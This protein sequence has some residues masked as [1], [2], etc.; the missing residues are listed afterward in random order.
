MLGHMSTQPSKEAV[1]RAGRRLASVLTTL[2]EDDREKVAQLEAENTDEVDDA[3]ALVDWWRSQ[4]AKP[5]TSV[6]ANLRHYVKPHGHRGHILVTQRLKR[7]PTVID[8]LL[9]EPHMKLTQ[10]AD[11]GVAA[12]CCPTKPLSIR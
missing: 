1:N 12:R 9:R 2:R 6:G 8:K 3:F 4:H 5:L 10:M 11:I 7:L